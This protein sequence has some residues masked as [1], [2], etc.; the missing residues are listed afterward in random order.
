MTINYVDL[1]S[2]ND[3]SGDGTYSLP[4]L[5]INKGDDGLTGGD[6]VR[7]ALTTINTLSGTLT[8]TDDSESVSTSVDL[9][10][11]ITAGDVIAKSDWATGGWWKVASLTSSVITLH[12]KYQGTGETVTGYHMTPSTTTNQ[13]ASTDGSSAASR[14]SISGGW[15]LGTQ[16]RTGVTLIDGAASTSGALRTFGDYQEWSYFVCVNSYD[17]AGCFQVPDDGNY[18]HH[19]HIAGTPD[20]G[21]FY[22]TGANNALEDCTHTGLNDQEAYFLNS[23]NITI[24]RCYAYD[25]G[26]TGIN[27]GTSSSY[28]RSID[29]VVIGA[30]GAE[31]FSV[32]GAK[33]I[34]L[35]RPVVDTATNGIYLLSDAENTYIFEPDIS[36]CTR[37]IY[38]N[39]LSSVT[40]VNNP[41]FLSNTDDYVHSNNS[42]Y[43]APRYA[44]TNDNGVD[45]IKHTYVKV[46]ADTTDAR[47]GTCMKFEPSLANRNWQPMVKLG[48]H[49]IASAAADLDLNIYLKDDASFNGVVN[50]I[51]RRDSFIVNDMEDLTMT[52]SYVQHTITVAAAD[53]TVDSYVTLY[54][55]VTG[56]AGAVYADD[57]STG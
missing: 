12:H 52:T 44:V 51:A 23:Y 38:A 16:T 7:V 11:T 29:C 43:H 50:L 6:E 5:T 57:F 25:P 27:F 37:A 30:T 24:E 1:V 13:G 31:A 54:L 39:S 55:H 34:F 18:I 45:W 53:L 2:G 35:I 10:G 14:L 19:C 22:I 3:T 42:P 40:Y 56:T 26:D 47:S 20:C 4:Y 36:N 28:G 46:S 41:T 49:K 21:C 33:S 32:Y 15:N 9:T 17:Y 8:F 48:V